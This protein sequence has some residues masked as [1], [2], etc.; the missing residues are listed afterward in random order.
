MPQLVTFTP[1]PALD[2]TYEV[3]KLRVG[4]THRVETIHR[5]AGGKGLNT[6]SVLAQMGHPALA[7][8]FFTS[9]EYVSDLEKRVKQYPG[10][11]SFKALPMPFPNRSSVAITAGGDAT[12]FNEAAPPYG[13][14]TDEE[15][16]RIWETVWDEVLKLEWVS[17]GD[18]VSINGSFPSRTPDGILSRLVERLKD[19]GCWVLVDTSGDYLLQAADAKADCL[20][21]NV[22][23]LLDATGCSDLPSGARALLARGAGALLVSAGPDGLAYI[24]P[25][26]LASPDAL[27]PVRWAAPGQVLQGNPTGAGDAAVAG[28]MSA[29]AAGQD[30]LT[31]L[32]RAV[33]WSAAAVPAKVA[34][35]LETK[36]VDRIAADITY[37]NEEWR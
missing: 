11:F 12:I 5:R 29:L 31:A 27:L 3:E 22:R 9:P 1:N 2:I 35:V 23:E 15:I 26:S 21:P 7:T 18:F 28:F 30:V 33:A 16:A 37:R 10:N 17:P 20:K 36:M 13:D 25:D 34:G 8:G 14:A 19:K 32:S 6:A 4:A 24:Q